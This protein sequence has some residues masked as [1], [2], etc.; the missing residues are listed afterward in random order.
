MTAAVRRPLSPTPLTF[1]PGGGSCPLVFSSLCF[2]KLFVYNLDSRL[3]G[4]SKQCA[5]GINY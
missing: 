3:L 2:V 4:L 1:K 5:S